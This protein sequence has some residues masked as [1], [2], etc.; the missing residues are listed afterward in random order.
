M[1]S[2]P[3]ARL[4]VASMSADLR[5]T[6]DPFSTDPFSMLFSNK[7]GTAVQGHPC[8]T[9]REVQQSVP[10]RPSG[11]QQPCVAGHGNGSSSTSG[12]SVS[13]EG[14]RLGRDSSKL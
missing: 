13:L 4:R 10:V 1:P 5:N 14:R 3:P 8:L 11:L 9:V 7:R 6:T 2:Q 12:S